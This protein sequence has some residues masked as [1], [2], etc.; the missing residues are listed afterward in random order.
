MSKTNRKMVNLLCRVS[1][2]GRS[3]SRRHEYQNTRHYERDV[4]RLRKWCGRTLTYD[5]APG[6]AALILTGW[7]MTPSPQQGSRR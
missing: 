5:N 2:A 7:P 1:G 4:G 3:K 6:T